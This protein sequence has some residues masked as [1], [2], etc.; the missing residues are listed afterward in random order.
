MTTAENGPV[1]AIAAI[2][3]VPRTAD[4]VMIGPLTERGNRGAGPLIARRGR[5]ETALWNGRNVLV[6]IGQQRGENDLEETNQLNDR[7]RRAPEDIAVTETDMIV[8]AEEL[9]Y[10]I[11]KLAYLPAMNEI[12]YTQGFVLSRR[13][14]PNLAVH[15]I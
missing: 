14:G 5:E 12:P 4:V 11:S 1:D 10:A 6:G 3:L 2:A 8:A 9:S 15:C 13:T 7:A